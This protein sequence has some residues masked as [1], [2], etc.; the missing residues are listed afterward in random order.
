[1]STSAF[2]FCQLSFSLACHS[3]LPI[4]I[5]CFFN[6]TTEGLSGDNTSRSTLVTRALKRD[7][8]RIRGLPNEPRLSSRSVFVRVAATVSTPDSSSGC[9]VTRRTTAQELTFH[10]AI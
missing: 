6:P 10:W 8:S 3:N 4:S 9:T 1:M 2:S 7:T 5:L